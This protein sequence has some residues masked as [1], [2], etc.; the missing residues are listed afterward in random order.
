M[1]FFLFL[2]A[3]I[4]VMAAGTRLPVVGLAT[5][6]AKVNKELIMKLRGGGMSIGPLNAENMLDVNAGV[7]TL[8]AL[9]MLFAKKMIDTRFFVDGLG[10]AKSHFTANL[11]A[12]NMLGQSVVGYLVSR[13]APAFKGM[14]GKI[15]AFIWLGHTVCL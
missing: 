13:E 11:L 5:N 7:L 6:K 3:V 4:A 8:Y 1:K 12:F 15:S 9:Q 2:L 14:Y 10:N